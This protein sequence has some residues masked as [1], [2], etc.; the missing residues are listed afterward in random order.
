MRKNET[1]MAFCNGRVGVAVDRMKR[2][3]TG[4]VAENEMSEIGRR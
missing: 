3:S 2:S 1:M 4:Y